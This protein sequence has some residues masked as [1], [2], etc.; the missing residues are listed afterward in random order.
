VDSAEGISVR[1]GR[2]AARRSVWRL[3]P[4]LITGACNDDPGSVATYSQ[5]GAQYGYGLAWTLLFSYPL[6]VAIQAISAR[7]GRITGRGIAGNLR[8]HYPGWLVGA[9]VGLLAV[10]N[11]VN[12]AADL[13]AMGAVLKLLLEAPALLYVCLLALASVLFHLFT[14]YSRYVAVLKWLCLSLLSYVVCAFVVDVPWRQ[15][16]RALV[17][18]A[19]SSKPEYLLAVVAALGTTISPYLFFW[20]AQQEVEAARNDGGQSPLQGE[21]GEARTEFARIRFDTLLGMGLSSLVALFIVIT[22]ASTLHARGITT[23][24]TAAE[25]AEA[26]RAVGGRFTVVLFALGIVGGGLLTLPA[27]ANSAAYAVGEL[28]SRPVGP[29]RGPRGAPAF[30]IVA[31]TAVA[32]CLTFT[33]GNPMRALYLSAVLNGV[34]AVPLMIAMM[35]MCTREAFM[36]SLRLS[37]GLTVLGW[38]A[39][40][41]MA[42]NVLTLA[43]AVLM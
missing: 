12:L 34:I 21:A 24:Q 38:L 13:S 25:A 40:A 16:A 41:L 29:A 33:S 4:G 2:R 6:L 42:A 10:A 31:A 30:Y 5:V 19:W 37:G 32:C 23:L 18:P 8:L 11:I 3:G 15:V 9:L 43:V 26:L 1:V 39:T 36:G 28:L 17:L 7:M 20:Q 14:R 27:L 22:S 35:H